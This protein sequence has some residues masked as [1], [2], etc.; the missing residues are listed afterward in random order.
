VVFQTRVKET[1]KLCIAGA[2]AELVGEA[3]RSKL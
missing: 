1:G 2:G 3:G